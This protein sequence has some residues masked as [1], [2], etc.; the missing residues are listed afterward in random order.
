MTELARIGLKRPDL[1]EQR[2]WI[3]GQFVSAEKTLA[4]INPATGGQ[5]GT[6]PNLGTEHAKAA[7]A[8][9]ADALPDWRARSGKE[10]AIILRRW[11]DLMTQN[12][13]DLARLMTAEQGKPLAESRGEIA[14][15][16]SFVEWFAEEAKRTNGEILPAPTRDRR[17]VVLRQPVGV[18]AAVTPWNFPAAMITRKAA[19]AFA[20]GCTMV[21][22]PSE[23]TPYSA[24]AMAVLAHE[25][26]LPPGVFNIVTGDA[27]PIGA[28]LTSDPRVRK[29]TFT[30]STAVGKALAAQCMAT[31]KR[32][33][34]ELGGNAPFIVMDDANIDAAVDG[35]LLSKF[36]NTGQTCVCANR[37]FVQ[38]GIYDAFAEK[39]TARVKAFKIGD[40]LSGPTDQGPLIDNRAVK[41]VEHHVNDALAK[42]ARLLTG[43]KRHELGGTYF[44][45]TVLADVTPQMVLS[46]EETFGPVAGLFRFDTMAEVIA[47][48]NDTAAGL[49]AYVY[50]NDT[51]RTWA[52]GEGLEYGMVGVNTGIVA[53]EVIPFG[54]IK[55]S[56]I[57]R[58][59]SHLGI[60]EFL[61]YKTL[62][63]ALN[64]PG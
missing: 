6:I 62:C 30:G 11:F 8:A 19:P 47:M 28:V 7:V 50:T 61:E 59:G 57:G 23:L 45:P 58:E 15:A 56:G 37:I 26:G 5:I 25:A 42:G 2:A 63:L 41:K 16:A 32:V 33:S 44:E 35:A 55:E 38:A 18:V 34:L 48:A 10:R 27:P 46:Q 17:L 31:V 3:G 14:Y 54:G 20:A 9:A 49:A 4:V 36:R 53:S 43:G 40:G 39:F 60:D 52:L 51:N 29:F 13:E 12:S 22:K 1:F 21:L 24:L 64:N